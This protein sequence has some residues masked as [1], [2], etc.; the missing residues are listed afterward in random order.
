[1]EAITVIVP[2]RV[3]EQAKGK[4]ND[5]A[6]HDLPEHVHFGRVATQ[7]CLEAEHHGCAHDVD[8]PEMQCHSF[9]HQLPHVAVCVYHTCVFFGSSPFI[10]ITLTVIDYCTTVRC[11]HVLTCLVPACSPSHGG[12]VVVLCFRHKPSELA[13]VF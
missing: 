4:E 12:D 13:H 6:T 1:M 5:G 2:A 10:S 9:P 8:K 11:L 3:D 7:L